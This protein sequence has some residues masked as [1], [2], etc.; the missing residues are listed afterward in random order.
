MAGVRDSLLFSV[1]GGQLDKGHVTVIFT[2]SLS[3]QSTSLKIRILYRGGKREGGKV[4]DLER[5]R[6]DQEKQIMLVS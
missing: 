6:G 1:D 5:G 2:L 3:D 4:R